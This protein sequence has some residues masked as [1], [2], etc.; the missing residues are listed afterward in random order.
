MAARRLLRNMGGSCTASAVVM[1]CL[2]SSAVANDHTLI[3]PAL[4]AL[5]FVMSASCC[6]ASN[7]TT[8]MIGEKQRCV[9]CRCC[10]AW[11]A[12]TGVEHCVLQSAVTECRPTTHLHAVVYHCCMSFACCQFNHTSCLSSM[13]AT[14]KKL[15][16]AS[17][18]VL[19]SP[20]SAC[21]MLNHLTSMLQ[22]PR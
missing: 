12:V 18:A 13:P 2:S 3:Q 1:S 4:P 17:S 9:A 8:P 11:Q 22:Q 10:T 20:S 15:R 14:D 5:P 16:A 7:R 21:C 19:H 6:S